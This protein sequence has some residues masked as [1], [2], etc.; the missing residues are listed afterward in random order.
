MH[1]ITHWTLFDAVFWLALAA[2]VVIL[3]PEPRGPR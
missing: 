2:L 3:W 1:A